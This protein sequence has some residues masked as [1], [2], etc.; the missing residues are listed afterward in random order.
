[1][2]EASKAT[3]LQNKAELTGHVIYCPITTQYHPDNPKSNEIRATVKIIDT[4]QNIDSFVDKAKRFIIGL[5]SNYRQTNKMCCR[6]IN[7]ID[8][9][10][11][12]VT[13]ALKSDIIP[14]LQTKSN[15]GYILPHIQTAQKQDELP[16]DMKT[17]LVGGSATKSTPPRK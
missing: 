11:A 2:I 12:S 16:K 7:M 10:D 5:D 9:F 14:N 8:T 13:S 1:M 15:S 3:N 4:T 17:A 6:L